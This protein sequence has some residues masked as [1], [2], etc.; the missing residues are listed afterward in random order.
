[1]NFAS[2]SFEKYC[3]FSVLGENFWRDYFPPPPLH[4]VRVRAFRLT[5]FDLTL[6][7]R[8][9]GGT[10]SVTVGEVTPWQ[11]LTRLDH[12]IQR[13]VRKHVRRQWQLIDFPRKICHAFGAPK[14][15]TMHA[16]KVNVYHFL[17]NIK[18]VLDETSPWL[19][20][21]L[22]PC[23]WCCSELCFRE[24]KIFK[25]ERHI[26]CTHKVTACGKRFYSTCVQH[27]ICHESHGEWQKR[28]MQGLKLPSWLKIIC[29]SGVGNGAL[30][31]TKRCLRRTA[32]L[33]SPFCFHH[34]AN[35]KCKNHSFRKIITQQTTCMNNRNKKQKEFMNAIYE[36][37]F[38]SM[39]TNQCL[40]IPKS[41]KTNSSYRSVCPTCKLFGTFLYPPAQCQGW[42]TV[43]TKQSGDLLPFAR[44]LL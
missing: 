7:C 32:L 13:E 16:E 33:E 5:W 20:S 34:N 19:Y 17:L 38:I 18:T 11:Q 21:N 41:S 28:D 22:Q 8:T 40:W 42:W 25:S 15:W 30:K 10:S 3:R 37:F 29:W 26:Y 6:Q 23:G 27:W 14:C 44:F 35:F 36:Y 9:G 12:T 39:K 24:R 1:M 4:G 43:S 2:T 31:G